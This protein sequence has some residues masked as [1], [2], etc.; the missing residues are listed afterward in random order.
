MIR[1]FPSPLE[2]SVMIFLRKKMTF[3]QT[4]F[5]K[6][7]SAGLIKMVSNIISSFTALH[8]MYRKNSHS[9]FVYLL[10][11]GWRLKQVKVIL[12]GQSW[13]NEAQK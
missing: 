5:Q 8:Q 12:R 11:V 7:V 3:S 10:I 1:S 9:Y 2:G 13:A 6:N 4:G